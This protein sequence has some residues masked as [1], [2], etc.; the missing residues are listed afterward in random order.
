MGGRRISRVYDAAWTRIAACPPAYTGADLAFDSLPE[1][2]V[3]H[4]WGY[5][6]TGGGCCKGVVGVDFSGHG[7]G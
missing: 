5:V 4:H 6:S 3:F 1:F 2:R 7:R